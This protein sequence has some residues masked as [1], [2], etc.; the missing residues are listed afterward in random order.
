[1]GVSCICALLHIFGFKEEDV[2]GLNEVS[3]RLPQ[4]RSETDE[5]T[6]RQRRN[7]QTLSISKREISL[8]IAQK[9]RKNGALHEKVASKSRKRRKTAKKVVL[10]SN[11]MRTGE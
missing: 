5:K 3:A 2:V 9:N 8:Q 1:M 11:V 4:E 6:L 10:K 7:G